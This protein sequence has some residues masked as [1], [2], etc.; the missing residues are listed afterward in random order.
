MFSLSYY[1]KIKDVY[2]SASSIYQY[3]INIA[4]AM[5][6][7]NKDVFT[8]QQTIAEIVKEE[9]KGLLS[10]ETMQQ[11]FLMQL[12]CGINQS[13]ERGV[14]R[15]QIKS[16][17]KGYMQKV[18]EGKRFSRGVVNNF[19]KSEGV[20]LLSRLKFKSYHINLYS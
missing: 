3:Y 18:M 5:K 20:G 9:Y 7:K 14:D 16:Y 2:F 12:I 10:A 17:V 15:K 8:Y 11:F 13:A 6:S 4:G 19:L 1:N